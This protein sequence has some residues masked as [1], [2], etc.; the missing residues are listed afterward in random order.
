MVIRTR[1]C[2]FCEYKIYPGRGIVYVARDGSSKL[3]INYKAMTLDKAKTKSHMIRWTTAWRR[4][5]KKL[6]T[7]GVVKRRRRKRTKKL[8]NISGMTVEQVRER[9][10]ANKANTGAGQDKRK[11]QIKADKRK[12]KKNR[13]AFGGK[14][15]KAIRKGGFGGKGR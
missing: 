13:N 15:D 3:Y 2:D 7:A 11:A 9:Q 10:R 1:N 4:K 6:K 12:G 14:R 8:R 5:N